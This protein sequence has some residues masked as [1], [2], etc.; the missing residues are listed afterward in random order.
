[1]NDN[2][3][4]MFLLAKG[5]VGTAVDIDY[6]YMSL[7]AEAYTLGFTHVRFDPEAPFVTASGHPDASELSYDF[8][9]HTVAANPDA[10]IEDLE[11]EDLPAY[12]AT[13]SH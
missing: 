4:P 12:I 1:M 5:I 10:E 9:S 2:F 8:L 7:I 3:N 11:V 13:H 6:R